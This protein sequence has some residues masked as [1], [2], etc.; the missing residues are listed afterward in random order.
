MVLIPSRLLSI[1]DQCDLFETA[2][3]VIDE[4]SAKE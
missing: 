2:L 4:S 3:A 1:P